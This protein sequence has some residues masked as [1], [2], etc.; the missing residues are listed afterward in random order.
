MQVYDSILERERIEIQNIKSFVVTTH[1]KTL[2]FTTN[3]YKFYNMYAHLSH[4]L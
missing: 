3:T 1:R 4:K 2:S